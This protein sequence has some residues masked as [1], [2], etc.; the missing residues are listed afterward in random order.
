MKDDYLWDKTGEPDPEIQHMERVLG[1]LRHSRTA[2][3]LPAFKIKARPAPHRFSKLLA[4]A[5]ALSFVLLALGALAAFIRQSQN[6]ATEDARTAMASP[7]P[8]QPSAAETDA[9]VKEGAGAERRNGALITIK[10]SG[11]DRKQQPPLV[12]R[13]R[14]F[15]RSREADINERERSEGLMAKQQL[16]KAL[17]ITSS[18]LNSVQKKVQGNSKQG[19]SS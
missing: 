7:V 4:I 1:A 10:G 2:R 19:P 14:N 15:N 17:Q 12:A 18:E 3:D 8:A 13:R 6:R 11:T 16:I 9:P 5:A